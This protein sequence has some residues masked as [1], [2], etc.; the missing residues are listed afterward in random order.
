MKYIVLVPDGL[1]DYPIEQLGGKTPVEVAETPNMDYVVEHGLLAQALTIPARLSPASD[2]ANLSIMGYDPVKYYTGRAPLEAAYL[3]VDLGDDEIAFRCNLVTVTDQKMSDYSAG[4]IST[5]EAAALIE[6]LNRGLGSEEIR[7]IPGVSYRHLLVLKGFENEE[8]V[9]TV[10][11]PPHDIA[12]EPVKKHLPRGKGAGVLLELM[13]KSK[14]V[15]A[16]QEINKVR[17]DLGENPANMIWL[18][19]LGLKPTLPLF[20]EKFGLTGAVISAVDLIKGI[21]KIIGLDVINVEGATGYYDTNYQGKAEAGL[22]ALETRDFVFIHVEATDEAGHNG[23]LRMKIATI[24]R[25]DKMVVGTIL[26]AFK[27][28]DDFR[29]MVLP[30]HATPVELR[31][32]VADKIC[33]AMMGQGIAQNGFKVFSEAE[34]KNSKMYFE[35]HQLMEVF[36]R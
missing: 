1:A 23:D 27:D 9:K 3:G 10:C 36:L 22:R 24:E 11:C 16:S 33:V 2:V 20:R 25:F 35:G 15:L 26:K 4:H 13:E 12:N 7:F 34:A 17:I 14:T 28:R 32:H 18:W 29:I 5:K 21:G 8:L 19:G 30:D 31:K 6:Q